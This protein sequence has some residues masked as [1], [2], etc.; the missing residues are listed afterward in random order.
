MFDST[1]YDI[2]IFRL[3]TLSG[4]VEREGS[5]TVHQE[6]IA[7]TG[8]P[9]FSCIGGPIKGFGSALTF[10]E[11][12]LSYLMRFSGIKVEGELGYEVVILP[13]TE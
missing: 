11:G 9:G 10:A 6:L 5:E 13:I 7:N 12:I 8:K 1:F 4:G 3:T 2:R